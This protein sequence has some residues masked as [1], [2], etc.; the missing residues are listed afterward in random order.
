M[1]PEGYTKTILSNRLSDT[2]KLTT[3][4]TVQSAF[5][6]EQRVRRG[7]Q[8]VGVDVLQLEYAARVRLLH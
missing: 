2:K 1:S 7:E 6:T 4:S 5:I 3:A 8:D